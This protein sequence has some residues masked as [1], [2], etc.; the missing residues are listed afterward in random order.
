MKTL[1]ISLAIVVIAVPAMATN[2]EVAETDEI[3]PAV[4]LYPGDYYIYDS[5]LSGPCLSDRDFWPFITVGA[6]TLT[7]EVEDCCFMGDSMMGDLRRFLH[8]IVDYGYATSPDT[9]TLESWASSLSFF[10][11]KVCYLHSVGGYS[12]GYYLHASFE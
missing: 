9:F 11:L 2:F 3:I 10:V 1:L 5:S 12:A 6:G 7:L 4:V 8:G